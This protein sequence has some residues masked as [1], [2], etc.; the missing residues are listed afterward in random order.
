[1]KDYIKILNFNSYTDFN[2][3]ILEYLTSKTEN[4]I[5]LTVINL[6]NNNLIKILN[7]IPNKKVIESVI[8]N[9]D[10]KNIEVSIEIINNRVGTSLECSVVAK[11]NKEI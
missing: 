11:D 5:M 10:I 3:V 1:M 2:I 9:K 6:H 4:N 7:V 8:I